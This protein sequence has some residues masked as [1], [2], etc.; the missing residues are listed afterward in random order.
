MTRGEQR[1]I[2]GRKRLRN[3]YGRWNSQEDSECTEVRIWPARKNI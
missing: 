2:G 1:G 3:Q